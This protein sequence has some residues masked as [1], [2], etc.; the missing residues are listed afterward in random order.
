[1]NRKI[2]IAGSLIL[3]V[4]TV[5]FFLLQAASLFTEN[6]ITA[7]LSFGVC[8]FLSWGYVI[9]VI[10]HSRL[11]PD[12]RKIAIDTSKA[13][14]VI[15]SVFICI[16]Y[17]SQ[18][19]VVRQSVLSKDIVNAFSF[20]YPG[21]WLFA[22]DIIGY[23][24]MALSTIFLGLSVE[25]GSDKVLKFVS[26]FHGIFSVCMFMPMTT[27]FLKGFGDSG[28]NFGVIALMSWC[29]IFFPIPFCSYRRFKRAEKM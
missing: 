29:V 10:G 13:L 16:V 27:L 23:G 26:L 19:T 14:G 22:I 17:F 4:T 12:D 15:Y 21:S 25:R 1:M 3:C 5:L 28:I 6:K 7:W 9:T 20:D 8:V 11:C 2:A 24:I 18:L